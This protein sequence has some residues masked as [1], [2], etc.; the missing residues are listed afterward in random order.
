MKEDSEFKCQ[1]YEVN[2][3]LSYESREIVGKFYYLGGVSS[4][5]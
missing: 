3:K 1:G 2:G 5:I 4:E